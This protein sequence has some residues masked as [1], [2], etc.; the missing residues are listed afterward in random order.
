[1]VKSEKRLKELAAIL[2]KNNDE[3]SVRV[4]LSLREEEPFEGAVTLL[5][6]QYDRTSNALLIKTIEAFFNDLR[7]SSLREEVISEVRKN[8]N[9]KTVRMLLSS[10]WQSGLDYSDWAT[11][12]T[13]IFIS[14][15]YNLALEC[16]TILE[17]SAGNI[18]I[19]TRKKM[20]KTIRDSM[21]PHESEKSRLSRE[22][23]NILS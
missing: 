3:E 23:I 14:S 22:L 9:N 12:I 4:I 17:Y 19:Q 5:A 18:T 16:L 2:G 13:D 1:M 15:D 20:I 8:Y 6:E 11:E 10:C 21:V 7:D